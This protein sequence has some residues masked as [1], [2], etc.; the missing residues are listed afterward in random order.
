MKSRAFIPVRLRPR[1]ALRHG[2]LRQPQ[3]VA[4]RVVRGPA[5]R[6]LPQQLP[7]RFDPLAGA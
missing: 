4:A 3:Q 2:F 7:Q 6:Q 5:R 1:E